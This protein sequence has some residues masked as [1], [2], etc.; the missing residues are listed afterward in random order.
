VLHGSTLTA[1]LR[2]ESA[3]VVKVVFTRRKD[4]FATDERRFSDCGWIMAFP[5][6]STE[7]SVS[8]STRRTTCHIV[9]GEFTPVLAK[10]SKSFSLIDCISVGVDRM[11]RN[12]EP[13]RKQVEA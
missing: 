7:A 9:A 6:L 8:K 5:E 11:Q 4:S 13:M 12:F 3:V 10:D 2:G 1:R